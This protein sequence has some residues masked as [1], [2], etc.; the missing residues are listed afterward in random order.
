MTTQAGSRWKDL[1]SLKSFATIVMTQ[2]SPPQMQDEE[3]GKFF[4]KLLPANKADHLCS[5]MAS[6]R[7]QAERNTVC[8][9][10]HGLVRCLNG[11]AWPDESTGLNMR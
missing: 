10:W 8:N 11:A 2:G 5:I 3:E 9:L 1:A 7:M 4:Y 6:L